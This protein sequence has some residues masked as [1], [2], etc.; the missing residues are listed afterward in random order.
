MAAFFVDPN[1]KA[2][3]Q[4]HSRAT[5]YRN[6]RAIHRRIFWNTH[7]AEEVRN[8]C[9]TE[10]AFC[11]LGRDQVQ[12]LGASISA[13]NRNLTNGV[14]VENGTVVDVDEEAMTIKAADGCVRIAAVMCGGRRYAAGE[15]AGQWKVQIGETLS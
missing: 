4:D 5:V 2:R 11:F 9:R 10:K 1:A 15:F 6:D 14:R 13:G 7:T 8:L 12:L 3:P